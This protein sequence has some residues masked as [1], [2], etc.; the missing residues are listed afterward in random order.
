MLTLNEYSRERTTQPYRWV[1]RGSIHNT[2]VNKISI[3]ICWS[4]IYI[5]IYIY[6]STRVSWFY[7][8]TT[9][10]F[11]PFHLRP[12]QP[13]N[14]PPSETRPDHTL[15]W[16]YTPKRWYGCKG[17]HAGVLASQSSLNIAP[18]AQLLKP[19]RELSEGARNTFFT[20][21]VVNVWNALSPDTVDFTSLCTFKHTIKL[22][23]FSSF[24]KASMF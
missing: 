19:M 9:S 14:Y 3:I 7:L 23:D 13:A 20:N 21:R 6:Y 5:Y 8:P 2:H 11:P 4:P 17:P 1:F 24:L 15:A 18:C 12:F 16:Q 22:A 10:T